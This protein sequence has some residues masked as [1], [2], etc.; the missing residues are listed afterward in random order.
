M[1]CAIHIYWMFAVNCSL[2]YSGSQYGGSPDRFR[3][4]FG[5]S[6]GEMDRRYCTALHCTAKHCTAPL[7]T[8]VKW[9]ALHWI[10]LHDTALHCTALHCTAINCTELQCTAQ[11]GRDQN[12]TVQNCST[13]HF[14][15][16]YPIYSYS[17]N[18]F[19]FLEKPFE[20]TEELRAFMLGPMID[21]LWT[22]LHY[23]TLQ[24]TFQV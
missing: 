4:E 18:Q 22:T 1:Y 21:L 15:G 16:L 24:C 23:K 9:I 10:A 20:F 3:A 8:V 13:L 12:R 17:Y 5:V 7:I 11:N 14:T 19:F 6:R 2:C